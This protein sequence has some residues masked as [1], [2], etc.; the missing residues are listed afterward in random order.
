MSFSELPGQ[1]LAALGD[2][3]LWAAMVIAALR[4]PLRWMPPA[5]IG[6]TLALATL[7]WLMETGELRAAHF[8]AQTLAGRALA[9]CLAG[10]IVRLLIDQRRQEPTVRPSGRSAR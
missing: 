6:V 4:V 2:P 5:A 9:A 10:V 1:V 3:L 7:F 8:E